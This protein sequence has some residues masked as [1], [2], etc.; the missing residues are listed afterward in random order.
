MTG[1]FNLTAP[2]QPNPELEQIVRK[3]GSAMTVPAKEVFL[4][5]ER[6]GKGVYYIVNGRTRH[7]LLGADGME[8]VFFVLT[9]GWFFEENTCFL[10]ATPRFHV[11]T[12]EK[13]DLLFIPNGV[14]QA[15]LRTSPLFNENIMRCLACKVQMLS[16][17]IESQAFLSAK[18]RLLEL[19]YHLADT[20][21]AFDG[22]WYSLKRNYPQ[23]ELG[24]ILGVSRVSISKFVNEFC[25][26]GVIRIV[27][28]RM[29][30]NIAHYRRLD[31][32]IAEQ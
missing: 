8:K 30:I 15:L 4:T 29:Q 9:S 31:D 32:M 6:A 13:T 2:V 21:F 23:Q 17:E 12:E 27:N 10:S 19:L 24:A 5:E 26:E 7:Y 20:S 28:R 11:M 22:K 1:T 18:D 3:Y 25:N 14:F 16:R